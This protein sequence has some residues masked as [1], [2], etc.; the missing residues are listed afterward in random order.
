MRLPVHTWGSVL[1]RRHT[2]TV[3]PAT[4]KT[5]I[6][7]RTR[8]R[9]YVALLPAAHVVIRGRKAMLSTRAKGSGPLHRRRAGCIEQA[10]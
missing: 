6:T 10:L 7:N 5:T 3:R 1:T 8:M 4:R 2:M 9:P